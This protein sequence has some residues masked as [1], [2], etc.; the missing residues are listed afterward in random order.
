MLVADGPQLERGCSRQTVH[1]SLSHRK[2]RYDLL[3]LSAERKLM[4][5]TECKRHGDG[6]KLADDVEKLK[7][8]TL[9]SGSLYVHRDL[10][11]DAAFGLIFAATWERD[12][13]NWFVSC[14]KA[15]EPKP[16]LARLWSVAGEST[17]TWG[18]CSLQHFENDEAQIKQ[19]WVIYVLFP[20]RP[21]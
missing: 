16:G 2:R 11:I 8:F 1:S 7:R 3:A 6:N 19:H 15:S 21:K 5:V 14:P 4:I 10:K 12:I 9:Q 20:L 13:A 17:A 18:A